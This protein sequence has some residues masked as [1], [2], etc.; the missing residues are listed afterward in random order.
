ML[1]IAGTYYQGKVHLEKEVPTDRPL[2]VVIVFEED[3]Q[4]E[5]KGFELSDFSFMKSRELLKNIKGSFSD[6]IIDER[7]EAL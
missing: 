3:V 2:K 1:R 6:T 5:Q 7:R 4:E